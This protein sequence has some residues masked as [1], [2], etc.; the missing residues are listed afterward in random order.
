MAAQNTIKTGR[1]SAQ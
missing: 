1:Y